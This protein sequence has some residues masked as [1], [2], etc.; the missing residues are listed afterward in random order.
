MVQS[1]MQIKLRAVLLGDAVMTRLMRTQLEGLSVDELWALRDKVKE[2]LSAN[3]AEEKHILEDRLKRLWS[4]RPQEQQQARRPYPK[5]RPR[6]RNP[7]WPAQTWSG[8]GKTPRWFSDQLGSGKRI[9]EL[10]ITS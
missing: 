6:Y 8:R 1:E 7:D 3:V 5:V 9:E 10:R 2:M 4:L